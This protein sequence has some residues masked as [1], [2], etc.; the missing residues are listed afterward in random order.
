MRYPLLWHGGGEPGRD[1]ARSGCQRRDPASWHSQQCRHTEG[2]FLPLPRGACDA[3]A[4]RSEWGC[5]WIQQ[6]GLQREDSALPAPGRGLLEEFPWTRRRAVLLALT[7]AGWSGSGWQCQRRIPCP[8]PAQSSWVLS[9]WPWR[10]LDREPLDLA[11]A[12]LAPLSS[13]KGMVWRREQPRALAGLP[14]PSFPGGFLLLWTCWMGVC[15]AGRDV[16]VSVDDLA[17]RRVLAAMLCRL[18]RLLTWKMQLC[19]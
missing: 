5:S 7:L 15:G 14:F 13:G 17:C 6:E 9:L 3:V 2:L 8:L 4:P 16:S 11:R 10:S 18:T 1:R 12:A 19:W